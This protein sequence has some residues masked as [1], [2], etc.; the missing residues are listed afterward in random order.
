MRFRKFR[1]AAHR[2]PGFTLVE[3]LCALAITGILIV[4]IFN[5][6]FQMITI[7]AGSSN[8][9]TATKQVEN[10]V[11]S[12]RRDA[13]QAQKI[14]PDPEDP[15]GFPLRFEWLTWNNEQNIITYSVLNNQL[16][17]T[18]S[19]DGVNYMKTLAMYITDI[20]MEDPDTYSG[21]EDIT[22]NIT[23]HIDDIRSATETRTFVIF[24]RASH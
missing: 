6:I 20:N 13:L 18:Q 21:V 11:D 4:G 7:N 10:A 23:S 19:I 15:S 12:M 22:L 17:R 1:K 5:V 9:M 2:Q 24:P 8:S 16:K 3:M 14:I